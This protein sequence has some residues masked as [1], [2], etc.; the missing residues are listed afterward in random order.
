VPVPVLSLLKEHGM[1][2]PL[3]V[4]ASLVCWLGGGAEGS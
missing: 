1:E 2:A 3:G 4:K